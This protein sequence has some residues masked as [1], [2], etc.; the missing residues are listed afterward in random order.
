MF[1]KMGSIATVAGSITVC[2][3]GLVSDATGASPEAIN[4]QT[5]YR[6]IQSMTYEF[7]SKLMTGYFVKQSTTCVVTL[8]IAERRDPEEPLGLSPTRVRL[9]LLPGQIAGLD[10]E[11]GKSLNF[12][13][14]GDAATLLV[15]VGERDRLVALQAA[16]LVEKIAQPQ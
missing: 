2:A 6:P 12:T 11:E 13:C 3:W 4:G 16:S 8:M 5:R 1:R 15:D 7:G 10:S 9:I 14:E